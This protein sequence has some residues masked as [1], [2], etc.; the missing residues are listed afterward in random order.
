MIKHI[1]FQQ[2]NYILFK[3]L[4]SVHHS[5]TDHKSLIK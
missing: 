2:R 1:F 3:L 5:M 4:T